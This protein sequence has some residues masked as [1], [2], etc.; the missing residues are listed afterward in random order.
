MSDAG[1]LVFSDVHIFLD[2]Y[3][4]NRSYV[5][6]IT[7][8]E[9]K[10]NEENYL[11]RIIFLAQKHLMT[12]RHFGYCFQK[13]DWL[14]DRLRGKSAHWMEFDYLSKMIKMERCRN[15]FSSP[16]AGHGGSV[17]SVSTWYASGSE[18]DPHI[19]YI[20]LW[21]LGHERISSKAILPLPLI[22][23]EQ[24]SVTCDRMCTTYW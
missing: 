24:L 14:V 12:I 18:F 22:Q 9:W 1:P 19:W 21:R 2:F 5:S 23:E 16:E 20:L 11:N 13:L 6:N 8:N 3:G 4:S 15:I 10:K 17:R 7:A